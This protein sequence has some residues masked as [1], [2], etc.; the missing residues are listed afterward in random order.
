MNPAEPLVI[1]DFIATMKEALASVKESK[2][3]RAKRVE[4]ASKFGDKK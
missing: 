4:A 2:P 3:E 1:S